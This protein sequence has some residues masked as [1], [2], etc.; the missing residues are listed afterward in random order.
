MTTDYHFAARSVIAAY[1]KDGEP[2]VEDW[3]R[4]EFAVAAAHGRAEW[5]A[6]HLKQLEQ[7]IGEC[8]KPPDRE[9]KRVPLET[10][11][12]A[13]IEYLTRV[14]SATRAEITASTGIPAGSLSQLLAGDEFHSPRYGEW[15]LVRLADHLAELDRIVQGVPDLPLIDAGD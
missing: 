9:E 2:G 15:T 13:L 11:R 7:L 12:A 8:R 5:L 10:H 1:Q 6:D 14:G 3:L 4:R